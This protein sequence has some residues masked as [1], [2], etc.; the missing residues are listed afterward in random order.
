MSF[1]EYVLQAYNGHVAPGTFALCWVFTALDPMNYVWPALVTC[2]FSGAA[3]V[4]W[5]LALRRSSVSGC[6]SS[7]SSSWSGPG[8]G[9]ASAVSVGRSHAVPCPRGVIGLCIWLIAE[10]LLRDRSR[11]VLVAAA[12]C[13]S[14]R[15]C[16]WRRPPS[17]SRCRCSCV[18]LLG[19]GRLR[20]RIRLAVRTLSPAALVTVGLPAGLPDPGRRR[21]AAAL[22]PGVDLR[23]PGDIISSTRTGSSRSCS[24]RLSAVPSTRCRPRGTSTHPGS[25]LSLGLWLAAVLLAIVALLYRTRAGLALAMALTYAVLSWGLLLFSYR[26]DVGGVLVGPDRAVRRGHPSVV[27]LACMYLVTPVA[28]GEDTGPCGVRSRNPRCDGSV[29]AATATSHSSSSRRSS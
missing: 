5:G 10:W 15:A 26:Y 11:R 24:P 4:T 14:P 13:P 27:L 6:T 16:F 17:S 21:P 19:P 25:A 3:V 28:R 29:T 23:S 22:E 9:R 12:P 8:P 2:F 20:S 18:Y 1:R 7:P